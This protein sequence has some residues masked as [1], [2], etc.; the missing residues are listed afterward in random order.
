MEEGYG[1]NGKNGGADVN[2]L[3]QIAKQ[4][5]QKFDQFMNGNG[6]PQARPTSSPHKSRSRPSSSNSHGHGHTQPHIEEA[7]LPPPPSG[8]VRT[9]CYRLNLDAPV[10]L[11]PTHDHLGPM[12]YEPPVHLLPQY[13]NQ[14]AISNS[15]SSTIKKSYST[16]SVEKSPTQVAIS[17]ARIFRGITVD[18]N[19]LILSQNARATRSSRG[20]EKSSFCFVVLVQRRIWRN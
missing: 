19:G 8:A 13:W 10:I 5:N 1:A 17:T 7:P 6:D 20:K 16:E 4:G 15:N 18:K 12:P 3:V 2:K 14:N 11:S 9:R